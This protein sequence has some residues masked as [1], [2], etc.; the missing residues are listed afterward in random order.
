[1]EAQIEIS[2]SHSDYFT[3]NLVAIR[4][5]RR[6]LLAVKRPASYIKGSNFT[7]SPA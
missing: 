4:A 2:A 3:K 5:E 7:T 6:L 1:M